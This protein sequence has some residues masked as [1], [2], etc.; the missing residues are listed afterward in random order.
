MEQRSQLSRALTLV[1]SATALLGALLLISVSYSSNGRSVGQVHGLA[2]VQE[3]VSGAKLLGQ[4]VGKSHG[5]KSLQS[6][7]AKVSKLMGRVRKVSIAE[8]RDAEKAEDARAQLDSRMSQLASAMNPAK[9][10]TKRNVDVTAALDERHRSMN[11]LQHMIKS[12]DSKAKALKTEREHLQTKLNLEIDSLANA[13][14]RAHN[15]A[16]AEEVH[17][18]KLAETTAKKTALSS[19]GLTTLADAAKDLLQM[20][21]IVKALTQSLSA[22]DLALAKQIADSLGQN[23]TTGE[24]VPA[25]IAAEVEI[26]AA[27]K[28]A[29]MPLKEDGK[30][31]AV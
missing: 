5:G 18:A 30:T 14:I 29:D 10:S 22:K 9:K 8:Q 19:N 31:S 11:D 26:A 13:Q 12:D 21:A 4:V 3:G 1:A 27:E 24:P 15:L 17:K 6:L 28:D 2:E 20:P 16:K 23:I 25:E 7:E